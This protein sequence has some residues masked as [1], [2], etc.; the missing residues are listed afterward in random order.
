MDDDPLFES[1]RQIINLRDPEGLL[2]AG[3]PLD[4]YDSEVKDL[5]VL[6]RG[7]E[8]IT[9]DSVAAVFDRWFG[10]S[11]WTAHRPTEVDQVATELESMRRRLQS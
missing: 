1:V 7:K 10:G 11:F 5:V 9:A 3:A 6:V 8:V 2:E 4:E